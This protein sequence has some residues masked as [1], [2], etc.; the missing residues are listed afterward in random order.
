MTNMTVPRQKILDGVPRVG[1]DVHMCP[2][3]GSLYACLEYLGD[4]CDYE[5]LMGVTGA[6]FRR[7][8]N[9]DD[10]G[11]IDLSYLGTE[12]F[13]RAFDALG[14]NWR[15]VQAGKD[16]LFEAVVE[17]IDRGVPVISFGI[18]GPPEAGIVSGYDRDGQALHGW[19]YFQDWPE[20]GGK[21][22]APYQRRD[23]FETMDRHAGK[24]LI[25]IGDK[26]PSRPPACEVLLASLEWAVHLAH[27]AHWPTLPDHV[28]GLAAYDAWADALEV[29]ADYPPDDTE[30]MGVR[31]MVYGDQCTM[32]YERHSA[33]R[34]LRQM[35]QV[36]PGLAEHLNAAAA[37]YDQAAAHVE[38]I[39][40]WGYDMGRDAQ[41]GLSE[42]K[43]RRAFAAHVRAA[44]AEEAEGAA[45]L[46]R[47]L[48]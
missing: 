18:L 43:A 15:M 31:L 29:D 11:N 27:T 38:Q 17:S 28:G 2:F 25:V 37:C 41:L 22:D 4:P 48:A 45:H 5:Y 26:L 8:W 35:A 34:Y 3:P 6:A 32:L 39:W 10:G 13:R 30:V 20:H 19:S 33:A 24:D 9:R 14:Y 23:W 7:F 47:A 42:P 12:P 16:A 21:R 1:F 40:P 44:R 46:E 36:A